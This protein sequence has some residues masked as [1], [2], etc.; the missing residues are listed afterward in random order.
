MLEKQFDEEFG[1]Y[2]E[3]KAEEAQQKRRLEKYENRFI[4]ACM[5]GFIAYLTII[6][7]ICGS[8]DKKLNEYRKMNSRE[9]YKIE[10]RIEE[11]N[12]IKP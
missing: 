8:H 12:Y 9:N 3:M 11:P 2:R 10:Q 5:G 4:L 6:S 7:I 1:F